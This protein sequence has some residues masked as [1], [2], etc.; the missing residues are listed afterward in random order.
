MMKVIVR[1]EKAGVFFCE[2]K[3]RDGSEG[4]ILNARRLYYWDGA[5]TLSQMAVEGVKKPKNCKF[6][7]T[8]PEMTILGI[9][10]ILPCSDKAVKSIEGVDEW[11]A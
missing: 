10:E 4:V 2:I 5:A 1:T 11:K 7:I 6:T 9:I 8:V 3:E